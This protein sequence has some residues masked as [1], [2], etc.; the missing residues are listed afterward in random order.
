MV[1][2]VVAFYKCCAEVMERTTSQCLKLPNVPCS[3][4]DHII[5]CIDL[6]NDSEENGDVR[7]ECKEVK[8]LIGKGT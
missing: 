8:A 1:S 6:W 2:F 7:S 4:I 5:Y 3:K